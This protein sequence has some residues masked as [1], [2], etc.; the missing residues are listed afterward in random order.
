MNTD[1]D[2]DDNDDKESATGITFEDQE[3]FN[4]CDENEI[5]RA[6]ESM[7]DDDRKSFEKIKRHFTAAIKEKRLIVE[8]DHFVYT[9]SDKSPNRG[10]ILNVR[11][12]NF[13]ALTAMDGYK[14]TAAMQKIQN[15]IAAICGVE[16]RDIAQI[17]NLDKK[18]YTV[19]Q[20][21]A[22]LFLTD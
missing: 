7:G 20:D 16:K 2:N 3:F 9:V 11:R 15:F 1:N 13:R 18:D 5:D 10:K 17:A 4:W 8:G 14:D 12:P 6:I 22:I 19:L 21:V